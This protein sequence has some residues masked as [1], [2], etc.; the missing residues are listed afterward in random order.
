MWLGQDVLLLPLGPSPG[1]DLTFYLFL[2]RMKGK[3]TARGGL[4]RRDCGVSRLHTCLWS[5]ATHSTAD[6]AAFHV[7]ATV[8]VSEAC[9]LLWT[10]P[11]RDHVDWIPGAVANLW[12]I[13]WGEM[14]TLLP[15]KSLS[16]PSLAESTLLTPLAGKTPFLWMGHLLRSLLW[17]SGSECPW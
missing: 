6:A 2:G 10:W 7:A 8:T 16:C 4:E 5:P 3:V 1:A 12:N 15:P 11:S 13:N 9:A 17:L 14:A